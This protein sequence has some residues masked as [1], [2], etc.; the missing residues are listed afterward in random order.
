MDSDIVLESK[1]SL[2]SN[3]HPSKQVQAKSLHESTGMLIKT[4]HAVKFS[5]TSARFKSP[6]LA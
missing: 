5:V 4:I 2:L 3:T 6:Q 1:L